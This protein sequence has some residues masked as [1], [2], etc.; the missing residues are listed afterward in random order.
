MCK[1]NKYWCVCSIPV[2]LKPLYPSLHTWWDRFKK[3]SVTDCLIN[4]L[5]NKNRRV[6]YLYQLSTAEAVYSLSRFNLFP[7]ALI[8]M[9]NT[10]PLSILSWWIRNLNMQRKPKPY[11]AF[12]EPHIHNNN[13]QQASAELPVSKTKSWKRNQIVGNFKIKTYLD[14]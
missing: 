6:S 1:M 5:A 14:I 7:T 3:W 12:R 2:N 4:L 13:T 8:L 10:T 9:E 11:L